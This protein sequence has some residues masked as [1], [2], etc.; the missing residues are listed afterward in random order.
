MSRMR[1][2]LLRMFLAR[3]GEEA[4]VGDVADEGVVVENVLGPLGDR[5]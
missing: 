2:L 5:E 3:E 4:A 1:E